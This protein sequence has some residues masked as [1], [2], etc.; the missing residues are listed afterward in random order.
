[1][2]VLIFFGLHL[3]LCG[4]ALLQGIKLSVFIFILFLTHIL[5]LIWQNKRITDTPAHLRGLRGG[6]L[7]QAERALHDKRLGI[8]LLSPALMILLSLLFLL[9]FG[10]HEMRQGGSASARYQDYGLLSVFKL[11][12]QSS[13]DFAAV[14]AARV[15]RVFIATLGAGLWLALATICGQIAVTSWL[16][17]SEAY[18]ERAQY[19]THGTISALVFI[20][21]LGTTLLVSFLIL[22]PELMAAS[23]VDNST[24]ALLLGTLLPLFPCFISAGFCAR[25]LQT[26]IERLEE[27][28]I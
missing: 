5:F 25:W 13:A 24:K 18:Y 7:Y 4:L 20:G 6:E 3:L 10:L 26:A 27:E 16:R 12:A 8:A 11:S 1:M 28:D 23:L 9:L 14:N 22:P 17:R 19:P 15:G 21:F 2:T